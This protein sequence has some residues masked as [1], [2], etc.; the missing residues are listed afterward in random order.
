M[1]KSSLVSTDVTTV[2]AVVATEV[3]GYV[4]ALKTVAE[5]MLLAASVELV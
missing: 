3:K 5:V 1:A 4:V 2:V